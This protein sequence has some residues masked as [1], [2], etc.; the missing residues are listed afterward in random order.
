[1]HGAATLSMLEA[2]YDLSEG[3]AVTLR[4]VASAATVM[5][6]GSPVAVCTYKVEDALPDFGGACF[7][8]AEERDIQTFET[9]SRSLPLELRRSILSLA[10]TVVDARSLVFENYTHHLPYQW[11]RNISIVAVMANTGDG[12]SL[13]IGFGTPIAEFWTAPRV[14]HFTAVAEHL[15]AAWRLR[16]TLMTMPPAATNPVAELHVNGT[17]KNLAPVASSKTAREE[18]RRVVLMREQSRSTRKITSGKELWPALVAGQWSLIDAFTA[19]GT[20]YVVAYENPPTAA[21]LRALTQ[22]EQLVLEHALKGRSGKWIALE[23]G[24]SEPTIA[25]I[26]QFALRRL[27]VARI[28]DLVGPRTARFELVDRIATGRIAAALGTT[29]TPGVTILTAA[30]RDIVMKLLEG[31]CSAQIA[32]DRSA[33]VRTIANQLQSIYRKLGVGSRRELILYL[34]SPA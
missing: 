26:L 33:S 22:R 15:A 19:S 17:P 10:P 16:T 13:T 31:R 3:T 28:A 27:G 18:L 29:K 5:D 11:I 1:M 23:L 30:E 32:A 7:S 12:N 21:P 2:A 34:M 14:H 9:Q 20:R 8:R 6:A 25:R 4:R 24:F